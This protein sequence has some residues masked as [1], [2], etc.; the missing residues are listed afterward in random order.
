M[1]KQEVSF[2]LVQVNLLCYVANIFGLLLFY[3]SLY[4]L[5]TWILCIVCYSVSLR[6]DESVA[7]MT[8]LIIFSVVRF[9]FI[10]CTFT[11]VWQ[12]AGTYIM[13]KGSAY[14]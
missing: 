11:L 9:K 12:V 4:L 3:R 14:L 6:V 13:S 5:V 7:I 10:V 2:P 1:S 8:E